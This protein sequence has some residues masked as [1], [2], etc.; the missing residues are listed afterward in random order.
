MT[1]AHIYQQLVE[2]LDDV[3][4][5][6]SPD[7]QTIHYISHSYEKVWGKTTQSLYDQPLS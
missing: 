4:F 7:W 6:I 3:L 2:S 1:D 5:V